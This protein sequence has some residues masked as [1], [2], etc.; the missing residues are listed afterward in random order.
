[1]GAQLP[2]KPAKNVGQ[3]RHIDGTVLHIHNDVVQLQRRGKLG[4]DRV[5]TAH[6]GSKNRMPLTNAVFE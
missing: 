3:I 2:E 1:M 5:G 4:K 6:P